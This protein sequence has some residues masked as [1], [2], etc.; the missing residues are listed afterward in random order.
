M[1]IGIDN[2][3]IPEEVREKFK[4]LGDVI[5]YLDTHTNNREQR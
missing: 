4:T 3:Q 2:N 1:E 5:N